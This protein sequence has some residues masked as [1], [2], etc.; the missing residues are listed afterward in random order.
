MII[1]SNCGPN[2]KGT[3]AQRT[4]KEIRGSLSLTILADRGL[5]SPGARSWQLARPGCVA[6][7]GALAFLAG[8]GGQKVQA[9]QDSGFTRKARSFGEGRT[10]WTTAPIHW[11]GPAR[12]RFG[13]GEGWGLRCM[14]QEVGYGLRAG[15]LD[16]GQWKQSITCACWRSRGRSSWWILILSHLDQMAD[17]WRFHVHDMARQESALRLSS[18]RKMRW[19]RAG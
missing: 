3:K 10:I 17:A 7:Q 15:Q 16:C 14:G 9:G 8:T 18:A 5:A 4:R 12:T 19:K 2:H 13:R 11:A 6:R 1:F